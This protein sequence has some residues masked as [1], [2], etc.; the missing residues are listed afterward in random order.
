MVKQW[1]LG[2]SVIL[3]VCLP[4]W[5]WAGSAI[6]S[7]DRGITSI[8]ESVQLTIHVD[9]SAD[10]DPD[11][12]PLQQDFEILSQSQ[13]S[14]YSFINGHMSRSKDWRITLLP[15]HVGTL[16]IPSMSLGNMMTNAL[17]LKVVD[18]STQVPQSKQ[19]DI[20]L[21]MTTASKDTY[22]QA[23]I[24]VTVK[25]FRA[26]SLSQAELSEPE[27]K[28]VV[29][30]RLGKDKNYDT[31]L[32]QRRYVVTER[33]YAVFP[34]QSGL[35]HIPAVV[36]RGQMNQ[37]MGIFNQVGRVIRVHSKD[38]DVHV[39]AMPRDWD[40]QHT[41]LP[42]SSL[43]LREIPNESHDLHVGDSLTRTIEMRVHGLTAEQLPPLM[44]QDVAKGWKQYPDKPELKTEVDEHGVVGIRREKIALIPTE[45]GDLTLPAIRMVWWNTE[46]HQVEHAEV[47]SR[48]VT[49]KT[50]ANTPKTTP[51]PAR[52]SQP[53]PPLIASTGITD[54]TT[55]TVVNHHQVNIWQGISAALAMG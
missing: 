47:L 20:F 1:Y 9:G 19:Q 39:H 13:N 17:V 29:I 10:Q 23:Q 5:A 4:Q 52:Q 7:L 38:V 53:T 44:S 21:T 28:H 40:V 46:T 41:W 25:L 16:S 34:Q 6:A 8:E 32:N 27:A 55:Q 26:V 48:V 42:A 33:R 36:M 15:K 2:L 50:K 14:S 35:L 18:A 11:F 51:S 45:S 30:K 12:S 49:V 54:S 37:G 22:V 43:S 3:A 31:I 24:L